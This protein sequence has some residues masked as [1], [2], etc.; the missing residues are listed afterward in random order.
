MSKRAILYI[1]T[2]TPER[3]AEGESYLQRQHN[4]CLNF[5]NQH[6]F[7]VVGALAEVASGNSLHNR[8]KLDELRQMVREGLVNV[9]IL[10]SLSRL[11]RQP[12]KLVELIRE[13]EKHGVAV[14][15]VIEL[16]PIDDITPLQAQ[17]M[18]LER[19][20][21]AAIYAHM[22]AQMLQEQTEVAQR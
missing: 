9:V 6:E 18:T 4:A 11:S 3:L 8:P 20:R 12:D 21:A 13:A 5:C 1:R 17:A 10:H 14:F 2:A 7:E 19:Q 15:S 16:L 22:E